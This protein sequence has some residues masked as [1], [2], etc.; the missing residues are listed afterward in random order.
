MTSPADAIARGFIN[1]KI[2]FLLIF[3][4][5]KKRGCTI[6]IARRTGPD[7]NDVKGS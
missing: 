4:L 5:L 7:Q 3:L 1:G 6:T 2:K